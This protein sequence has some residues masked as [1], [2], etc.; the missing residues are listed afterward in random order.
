[1]CADQGGLHHSARRSPNRPQPGLAPSAESQQDRLR[2]K[3][4]GRR[5]RSAPRVG[6]SDRRRRVRQDT[7]VRR[8]RV[9]V[10]GRL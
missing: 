3:T 1:K 6:R 2:E 4:R 7:R 9:K 8:A 10:H 5:H